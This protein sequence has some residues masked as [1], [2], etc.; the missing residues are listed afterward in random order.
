MGIGSTVAVELEEQKQR[1]AWYEEEIL[2]AAIRVSKGGDRNSAYRGAQSLIE[3]RKEALRNGEYS[4]GPDGC[5]EFFESR[6]EGSTIPQ[7]HEAQI[8]AIAAELRVAFPIELS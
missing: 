7:G 6:L 8:K 1:E 4:E 5:I 3:D 2:E